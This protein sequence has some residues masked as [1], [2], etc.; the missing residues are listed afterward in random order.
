MSYTAKNYI[1][2]AFK[3]G[4]DFYH[5][6]GDTLQM[7][8]VKGQISRLHRQWSGLHVFSCECIAICNLRPPDAALFLIRF[9]VDAMLS[10]KSLKLSA[11]VLQRFWCWYITL[12]CDLDLWMSMS[13]SYTLLNKTFSEEC[14]GL[15]EEMGLQP[16]SELFTT[17]GGWAQVCMA[18]SSRRRGLQ[19]GSSV[20][21][22]GSWFE[23]PACHS[24]QPNGDM[25]S[26]RCRPR[27]W[28]C[29][30]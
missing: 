4:T 30:A 2:L 3:F 19:H 15:C 21:R 18:E 27:F 11:A 20:G 8:I 24:V 25:P 9:N 14:V 29:D 6:T 26:Q 12:R 28:S 7:F 10:L 13:M 5:V 23:E 17:D 22:T 1:F 16:I